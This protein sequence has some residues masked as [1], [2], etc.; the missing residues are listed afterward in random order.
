ME[1][2]VLEEFVSLVET[3]SFQETAAIMN[4]SQSSLT[5]HIHK[6]EEELNLTLF[7]RSSRSVKVNEYSKAFYPYAK[8]IVSLSQD[9][10]GS[11]SDLQQRDRHQIIIAYTPVL[12]QYGLVK[13]LADFGSKYPQHTIQT[14]ETYQPMSLLRPKK[15]DFVFLAENEPDLD[16]FNKMIYRTDHLAA[17]LPDSHPLADR[18]SVTIEQLQ[19][20]RFILH[21]SNSPA[22]HEETQK[23]L[24]L[25]A[26]RHIEPTIVA[27][28]QFTATMV[29]YVSAG[30]GIAVL[31][32]LHI[33]NEATNIR[34]VDITPTVRSYI[35]LVY[36]RRI[37]S[38]S[39]C[40]FLHFM[41]EHI[42]Q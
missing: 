19:N 21:S 5:K 14:I 38:T 8:Q 7:D 9:A 27:E 25:C 39:A 35:Y 42:S 28:S 13:T 32:R 41:V 2:N 23:F 31:N 34:I 1:I 33:P 36:P 12:G 16:D 22:M 10:L 15:C 18:D 20:E 30:R 26:S 37:T 11:L 3:C 17:V 24:D 4:V 29:R 6:L 40:D